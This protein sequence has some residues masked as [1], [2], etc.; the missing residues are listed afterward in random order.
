M[1]KNI[2]GNLIIYIP[3]FAYILYTI[4]IPSK[5]IE[6]I[7]WSQV[8]ITGLIGLISTAVGG[9]IKRQGKAE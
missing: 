9:R 8:I 3:T 6:G 7:D 2:L 1:D 5:E 4:V